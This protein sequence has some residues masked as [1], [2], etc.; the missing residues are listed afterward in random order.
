MWERVPQIPA[1]NLKEV[2]KEQ[3]IF[4]KKVV[5]PKSD[6][7]IVGRELKKKITNVPSQPS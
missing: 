7:L 3:L 6:E 1:S 4:F 5:S 2:I